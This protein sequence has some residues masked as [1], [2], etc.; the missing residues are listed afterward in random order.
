MGVLEFA[1]DAIVSGTVLGIDVSWSPDQVAK[2]MGEHFGVGHWRGSM[3]RDYGVVEFFWEGS[4]RQGWQGHHFTIQIHR[5]TV[6]QT[7]KRL[8]KAIKK[9]YG[10][11]DSTLL[12]TELESILRERNISLIELPN[13]SE[14]YREYWQPQTLMSTLVVDSG[15]ESGRVHGIYSNQS[16]QAVTSRS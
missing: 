6:N 3:R 14:G 2:V 11:F 15:E 5:L 16:A 1:A 4:D 8:N 13:P 12:F 7:R 9:R 10:S